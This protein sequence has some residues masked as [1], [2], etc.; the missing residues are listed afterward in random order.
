MKGKENGLALTGKGKMIFRP[1]LQSS[2]IYGYINYPERQ[3]EL[4]IEEPISEEDEYH[5][6][7]PKSYLNA[8]IHDKFTVESSFGRAEIITTKQKG[9]VSLTVYR[10]ITVNATKIKPQ[11]YKEF[12]QFCLD[13][14]AIEF[15]NI[16]IY[17]D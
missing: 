13:L 2:S 12:L 4:I 1:V 3:T 5:Y 9:S 15:K 8:S 14:K 10:K 7:L 17:E 16:T 6:I 11:D